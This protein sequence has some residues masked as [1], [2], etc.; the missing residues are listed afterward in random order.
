MPIVHGEQRPWL[1]VTVRP[2]VEPNWNWHEGDMPTEEFYFCAMIHT[3][4][5][6]TSIQEKRV[7]T[8]QIT[9][10]SLVNAKGIW[11]VVSL[12]LLMHVATSLTKRGYPRGL[13]GS[14]S[15]RSGT[16]PR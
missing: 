16:P 3:T 7:T 13:L 12:L 6:L 14:L 5:R 1:D 4:D 9:T 10:V 8:E 11:E 2:Y 15:E